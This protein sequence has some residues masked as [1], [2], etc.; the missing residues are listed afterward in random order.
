MNYKI[1][2]LFLVFLLLGCNQYSQNEKSIVFIPDQKYKNKGF[3][4]IYSDDLFLNKTIND[5]LV[6][7]HIKINIASRME[8]QTKVGNPA[9][10]LSP[11][12]PPINTPP[13]ANKPIIA[14]KFPAICSSI[15]LSVAK[16]AICVEIKKS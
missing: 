13:N 7:A 5:D 6:D 16:D 3:A 15:P 10:N 4:L 2:L 1:I 8:K 14:S 11:R 9:L 12:N